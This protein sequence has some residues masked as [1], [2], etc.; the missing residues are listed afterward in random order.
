MP[1]RELTYRVQIETGQARQ[2]AA[3]LRQAM[4]REL[5]QIK[6]GSLDTSAL[7]TAQ[8]DAGGFR[9]ALK[10]I[11]TE[12]KA[13]QSSLDKIK[14]PAA[15]TGGGGASGGVDGG[16]AGLAGLARG[17]IGGLGIGIAGITA[18]EIAE[19]TIE[20]AN[21]GTQANR[22]FK[23][24]EI[25]SG[26]EKQAAANLEAIVRA[27][28][29]AADKLKATEIANQALA[30]NLAKTPE[31]FAKITRAGRQVALVSPVIHDVQSAISELGLASANLSF[32]RLDQLGLTVTEVKNGMTEL[33]RANADLTDSEAFFQASVGALENKY[34]TILD[35]SEAAASGIE[36]LTAKLK[37]F[38]TEAAQTVAAGVD[39]LFNRL[40]IMAGADDTAAVLKEL[41][42]KQKQIQDD[43]AFS[44]NNQTPAL[45]GSGGFLFT[46]DALRTDTAAMEEAQAK[47]K[48]AIAGVIAIVK[49]SRDAYNE[50][51]YGADEYLSAVSA[52]AAE[53]ANQ[54][55]PTQAQIAAL[56]ALSMAY[57]DMQRFG[58]PVADTIAATGTA[59][60]GS[61]TAQIT[62]AQAMV[63][64]QLS[65]DNYIAI[66]GTLTGEMYDVA[67][68]ANIAASAIAG[69]GATR[70]AV[71]ANLAKYG[72]AS[73]Y[74]T[75]YNLNSGPST[76]TGV[77]TL[78]IAPS[79]PFDTRM[80]I[81]QKQT[82]EAQLGLKQQYKANKEAEAAA[83]RAAS[84]SERGAKRAGKA[85]EDGAK[86]ASQELQSA[87]NSV[88]GLFGRSQVTEGDMQLSKAGIY[89]DKA[90]EKLRR[91]QAEVEQGKDLFGDVSISEAKQALID[92]GVKV[93]DDEKVAFQ[94]FADA[95]ES[96]L[97]FFDPANIDKYINKE[98]VQR[99]L[100]LQK[101]AA[102][103]KDNIYKAFGV[104]I[105]DAVSAAVGG[106]S[107]GGVATGGGGYSIPI[108]AELMPMTAGEMPTLGGMS[109]VI[110]VAAIQGQLDGITLENIHLGATAAAALQAEIE[111]IAANVKVG[112]ALN[113]VSF[114]DLLA[115][116]ESTKPTIDV[117][118]DLDA[119][120]FA[121]LF[122]KVQS[123]KAKISVGATLSNATG[124]ELLLALGKQIGENSLA[125]L[126]QGTAIGGVMSAG[127]VTGLGS[128][129]SNAV[130]GL[131][132]QIGE[133]VPAF[134]AQGQAIGSILGGGVS[135]GFSS[136]GIGQDLLTAISTEIATNSQFF[137]AQG[138]AVGAIVKG[139]IA[140][141]F[142][143]GGGEQVSADLAMG[144]V[145]EL[146]RQFQTNANFFY[147]A[148]QGPAQ[149]VLGGYKGY[150]TTDSNEGA[151][152]VTPLVTAINT[153]IRIKAEDFKN[154]GITLA[155]YV[156]NGVAIGFNSDS[157]K[158]TLISVG[159][160]MYASIRTG[161][162]N[163]ADGGD[164]VD[165]LGSKILADISQTV[166]QPQ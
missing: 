95:W 127:V 136:G 91:L 63:S 140:S 70:A 75:E 124:S 38:R 35:S 74:D 68:A 59:A 31:E 27:S 160:S 113:D 42:R 94:Q 154:Q 3:A 153:Q 157:F 165:M 145:G 88:P 19:Q 86:K 106:I 147:A 135:T 138:Q 55:E 141:T 162:L 158:A 56:S 66:L 112:A 119:V 17:A 57:A 29:G 33:K 166:E 77:P 11:E 10:Q 92:L 150:F 18:R 120:S 99:D 143:A 102:E 137:L 73:K 23:S 152:L 51:K 36:L 32:R 39:P 69:M 123:T 90:D 128:A 83:K 148:G 21:L 156:Q 25:L 114:A 129:G 71:Q 4:E 22:T 107:G 134:G 79:D 85:L 115:K 109:P 54:S 149:N 78:G 121:D 47:A 43:L 159:E 131:G 132:R 48:A 110:D 72:T 58:A 117:S 28:G 67:D 64:G 93:A 65:A 161:L 89:L 49:E 81:L 46:P 60:E 53:I 45:A 24:F 76:A 133:Q 20:L 26:G 14:V 116:I 164:L 146:N 125:F 84:E 144:L 9:D 13:A 126:A 104:A 2:Q 16:G 130:L 62:L 34:G 100:D 155:G 97:L 151:P 7:K 101:K 87:L 37:D 98:A 15:G 105:D 52:I 12:A 139:G 6:L 82:A 108:T 163:A 96:G 103:G 80:A 1:S 30:L 122:E 41:E 40:A 8:A 44:L 5:K 118:T 50:G 61:T 111:A 142:G